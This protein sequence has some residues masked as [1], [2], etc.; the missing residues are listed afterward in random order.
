MGAIAD[1][2][3]ADHDRLDRL[4]REA[5]AEPGRIAL[6]PFARFREGLLRHIGLEEKVLF[7]AAKEARGVPVPE[8]ARL[9][10]DHGR[11]TALLVP[12]PTPALVADI[13]AVLEPHNALEEAVEGV[14][15]ACEAALGDDLG[16]WLVKLRETPAPPTRPHYDRRRPA[17]LEPPDDGRG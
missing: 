2:L 17:I 15:A 5:T 9:R 4:L 14:Y 13:R 1:Y 6:E 8:F 7:P 16:A 10:A 3:A 12:T 11:L